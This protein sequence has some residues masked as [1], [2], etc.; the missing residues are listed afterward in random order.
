MRKIDK[1]WLHDIKYINI[2][3]KTELKQSVILS[4]KL[5]LPIT[6][7]ICINKDKKLSKIPELPAC[8]VTRL[9][10]SWKW[11]DLVCHSLKKAKFL[12]VKT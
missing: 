4:A 7:C 10:K 8:S 12:S 1:I 3:K 5:I 6:R 11:L 9:E 2:S